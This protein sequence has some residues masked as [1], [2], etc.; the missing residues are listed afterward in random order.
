MVV[1]VDD[2]SRLARGLAAHLDL[3]TSIA[4]A[5]GTLKSPSIKFGE[6]ADS[7]LLET[8][9]ATVPQYGQ[10]KNG[11]QIKNRMVARAM[12]SFWCFQSPIGCIYTK[13][14]RGKILRRCSRSTRP[15]N[16]ISL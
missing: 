10:E 4:T 5:G 8:L 11:G 7:L 1:M 14:G 13:S 15:P 9:L 6:D 16:L 2:I 12:N 3:R